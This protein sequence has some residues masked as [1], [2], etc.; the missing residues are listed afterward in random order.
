MGAIVIT[1]I[2]ASVVVTWSIEK[3]VTTLYKD[4]NAI[5]KERWHVEAQRT[6]INKNSWYRTN[7][8]C[9]KILAMGGHE[10]KARCYYPDNYYEQMSRSLINTKIWNESFNIFKKVP[11]YAY[12]SG[13]SYAGFLTEI[14]SFEDVENIEEFPKDYNVN[15][16]PKDTRNYKLVWRVWE[17]KDLN[18]PVGE[19]YDCKYLFGDIKIDIND[20]KKLEKAVVKDK[21]TIWFYFKA[22]RGYQKLDVLLVDPLD[23]WD[24]QE[25]ATFI[26]CSGTFSTGHECIYGYDDNY[27]TYAEAAIGQVGTIYFN[28]TKPNGLLDVMWQ[29]KLGSVAVAF[30]NQTLS[31]NCIAETPL[32]L[33]VNLTQPNPG[34]V[35]ADALCYN[36]SDWEYVWGWDEESNCYWCYEEAMWWNISEDES[37]TT[38]FLDELSVDRYYEYGTIA[39]L[40]ANVTNSTGSIIIPDNSD[41]FCLSIDAVGFGDNYTC[42]DNTDGVIEYNWTAFASKSE[43]SDDSEEKNLTYYSDAENQTV[44]F[45]FNHHD[46]IIN[47]TIDLDGFNT[48]GSY[49]T[50]VK[51]Y[52]D[53]TLSNTFTGI[54]YEGADSLTELNDS[55]TE[56]NVTLGI[57]GLLSSSVYTKLLKN[58]VI[59]SAYV[60][61]SGFSSQDVFDYTDNFSTTTNIS[62]YTA[63]W[64][65][66]NDDVL[67]QCFIPKGT[68]VTGSNPVYNDTYSDGVDPDYGSMH[69]TDGGSVYESGGVLV[70]DQSGAVAEH[71]SFRIDDDTTKVEVDMKVVSIDSTGYLQYLFEVN[72]PGAGSITSRWYID[73]SGNIYL[74]RNYDPKWY[75]SGSWHLTSSPCGTYSTGSTYH[76]TS[77]IDGAGHIDMIWT[78]KSACSATLTEFEREKFTYVWFSSDCAAGCS[79]NR[80]DMDN[81]EYNMVDFSTGGNIIS[82]KLDYDADEAY[83]KVNITTSYSCV[84]ACNGYIMYYLSANGGDDWELIN[85]SQYNNSE[86]TFENAGDD[87]RWKVEVDGV[88]TDFYKLDEITISQTDNAYPHNAYIDVGNDGD[89]DWEFSG[90]FNQSDNRTTDFTSEIQDYLDSC[91]SDSDGYCTVPL[92]H[93]SDRAGILEASDLEI[94]YTVTFNPVTLDKDLMQAYLDANTNYYTWDVDAEDSYK[95][96]NVTSYFNPSYPCV[97]AVD[98]NTGTWANVMA[99]GSHPPRVAT[100]VYENFSIPTNITNAQWMAL[101]VRGQEFF[102]YN[103]SEWDSIYINSWGAGIATITADIPSDCLTGSILQMK[104]EIWNMYY[105]YGRYAEG[106]VRW[107]QEKTAENLIT[108]PLKFES[109][110]NG[111]IQISNIKSYYYGSDNVTITANYYGDIYYDVSN[112]TQVIKV[113]YSNYEYELPNNIDFPYFIPLTNESVNVTPEGQDDNTPIINLTA[114][115]Y[116][117]PFDLYFYVNETVGCVSQYIWNTSDILAINVPLNT[118]E[119]KILRNMNFNDN[120]GIWLKNDYAC[121]STRYYDSYDYTYYTKC[122]E[123]V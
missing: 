97:N 113:I 70:M 33:M 108:I 20:C 13:G 21:E 103:G 83:G 64:H 50:N 62:S 18:L 8:M 16:I 89:K 84:G 67:G 65:G 63:R 25:N 77:E 109:Q 72:S 6:Y 68:H 110:K 44:H 54:L 23:D 73:S 3:D 14:F 116:D 19:Y 88:G 34:N 74:Y 32:Q 56:K 101:I 22:Q 9:P 99:G 78:G 120:E 5:A 94:N 112:D 31:A 55:T 111:T 119:V 60:N 42:D 48:N 4:G 30:S 53:D 80:I 12:G 85:I 24:F 27:S 29:L 90:E 46:D 106:W 7:I 92:V 61:K 45:E 69:E 17:L 76:L 91:S 71:A 81:L 118:T 114:K 47:A 107:R 87:L 36:G 86:Y 102:C 43:L 1:L 96:E 121:G 115:G 93:G 49:P 117:Q 35:Q 66:T 98:E 11:F 104:D 58:A 28:Y 57:D 75:Y 10:T 59:S 39:S 40:K 95:C 123:C 82:D 79:D 41:D 38:L 122:T 2:L 26:S 51:I 100:I 37:T 105:D 15:W 52:I